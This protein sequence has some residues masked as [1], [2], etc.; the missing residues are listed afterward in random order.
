M[1][2][3]T[4]KNICIQGQLKKKTGHE[5]EGDGNRY[6]DFG[7]GK[8]KSEMQLHYNLEKCKKKIKIEKLQPVY[9][10]WPPSWRP[11]CRLCMILFWLQLALSRQNTVKLMGFHQCDEALAYTFWV[12]FLAFLIPCLDGSHCSIFSCVVRKWDYLP[13]KQQAWSKIENRPPK[14]PQ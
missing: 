8:G 3:Y 12:I 6:M 7:T 11:V 4:H 10:K 1:C 14:A 9:K 13:V 5:F 2:A